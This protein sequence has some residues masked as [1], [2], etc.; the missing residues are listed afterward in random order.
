MGVNGINSNTL[1]SLYNKYITTESESATSTSTSLSSILDTDT[2]SST[3]SA[4]SLILSSQS[5]IYCRLQKMQQSDPEQFKRVCSNI[6]KNLNIAAQNAGGTGAATLATKF[7]AAAESGSMSDLTSST[8][9]TTSSSS[10]ISKSLVKQYMQLAAS[11]ANDDNTT[12]L[13]NQLLEK[14]GIS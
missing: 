2:S 1:A 10:T 3:D 9:T 12:N 6:A 4:D 14:M 13:I 11:Q 5:Q 8:T 7:A